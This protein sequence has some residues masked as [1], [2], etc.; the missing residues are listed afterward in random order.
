MGE[1]ITPPGRRVR[2]VSEENG[3][4]TQR[5]AEF[6]EKISNSFRELPDQMPYISDASGAT[7]AGNEAK[8]NEIL[9]ALRNSGLMATP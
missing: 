1:I 6:F 8:I 7:P 4:P 9:N 3:T 2:I 5:C